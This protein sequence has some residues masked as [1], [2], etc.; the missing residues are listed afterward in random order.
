MKS[1]HILDSIF[2]YHPLC[3]DIPQDSL[4]AVDELRISYIIWDSC[5]FSSP[6]Q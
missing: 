5:P 1:Y 6:F 3:N 2:H 4:E